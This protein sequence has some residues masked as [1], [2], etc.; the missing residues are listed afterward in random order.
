VAHHEIFNRV[1]T[2][3]K[4][5]FA[6]QLSTLI[7]AGMPL[8]QSLRAV[9]NQTSNK[10]LK[11]VLTKIISDVE[12]GTSFSD[13]LAKHP[14]IF[15]VVFV[16]LV[17]AGEA[18]GTLD[19][20][21]ERL[22]NQQEKDAEIVSK[23]R[24]A[25]MYP[26]IVVVVMIGV[27]TFMLTAVLPQV[28]GLY[29]GIPGAKLPWITTFLLSVSHLITTFWWVVL[30][31]VIGGG[32]FLFRWGKAGPGK[33]FFDRVKLN[34][35]P[36]NHLFRKVYMARFA[37]TAQSMVASGVPLLQMM[38]ITGKAVGNIPIEHSLEKA[39]EK[40]KGGI[41]LSESLKGDNNFLDLVPNMIQIGEESGSLETMLGKTADYYEKEVDNEVK[42]I[43]TLIEPFLMIMLGVAALIIV[44]AVLLP[45][46]NL[47][48]KFQ[49]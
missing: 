7:N 8:M 25:L 13:A 33:E 1:R 43:S 16:S 35:W 46:Y 41:A 28:Q 17:A 23:V 27:V 5:I 26:A 48:G 10:A 6:R 44:A 15:N 19:K 22:S 47:A 30:L 21:L 4:I 32:Y 42:T 40:V 45:I 3:D 29:K 24:G 36:I 39:T 37:R 31:L 18:S 20:T 14:K 38:E 12:G 49:T 9:D 34:A 2:K 11:E